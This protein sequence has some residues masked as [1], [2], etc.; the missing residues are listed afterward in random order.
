MR[1]DFNRT[2]VRQAFLAERTW[3]DNEREQDIRFLKET[4]QLVNS[5][6]RAI[7]NN[8]PEAYLVLLERLA[9]RHSSLAVAVK[10]RVENAKA[11]WDYTSE[12]P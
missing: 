3:A 1:S 10:H 4:Y 12:W 8:D 5:A 6:R 11:E 9:A 7:R 2:Q